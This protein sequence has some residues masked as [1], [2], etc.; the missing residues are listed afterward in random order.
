MNEAK[1]KEV[2]I[3]FR[4]LLSFYSDFQPLPI[5]VHVL[6]WPLQVFLVLSLQF[7]FTNERNSSLMGLLFSRKHWTLNDLQNPFWRFEYTQLL[8]YA[9]VAFLK[10]WA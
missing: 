10:E 7:M 3:F 5:I 1:R 4:Y 2:R 9:I 8:F 6:V